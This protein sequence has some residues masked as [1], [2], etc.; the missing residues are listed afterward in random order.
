[1]GLGMQTPAQQLSGVF[2][3]PSEPGQPEAGESLS[4]GAR[5]GMVTTDTDILP[6]VIT[7]LPTS[8]QQLGPPPR[9]HRVWTE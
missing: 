3:S 7:G 1:M 6:H 4:P 8:P 9:R 2:G 5:D